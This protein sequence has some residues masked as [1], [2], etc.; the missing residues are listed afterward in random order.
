MALSQFHN[1]EIVISVRLRTLTRLK[2]LKVEDIILTGLIRAPLINCDDANFQGGLYRGR[3]RY[4]LSS[5]ALLLFL[6]YLYFVM[7]F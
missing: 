3:R 5:L 2:L 4:G 7:F 6:F 1:N